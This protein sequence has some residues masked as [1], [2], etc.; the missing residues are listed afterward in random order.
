MSEGAS[1]SPRAARSSQKAAAGS[2]P[3]K[4]AIDAAERAFSEAW[5]RALTAFSPYTRL[6]PP[7]LCRT[8]SDEK[9]EGLEQSFAM[10]RMRDERI[11]IGLS[12]IAALSLEP[13]A[14][15]ILAHE[16]GHYVHAPG[17]LRDHVRLHDR[18]RRTLPKNLAPHAGMVSNLYTDLLLNDR[19]ER[20]GLAD[21]AAVYVALRSEA[22]S[23]LWTFYMRTYERLWLLRP[24]TL[25]PEPSETIESDAELAA[26]LVRHFR[27]DW[28]SGAPSFALL[29]APYL[30]SLPTERPGLPGWLD[31][32]ATSLGEQVPDGLV[33]DDFD[34]DQVQHPAVDARLSDSGASDDPDDD[35]EGDAAADAGDR[36]G[37]GEGSTVARDRGARGRALRGDGR[38]DERR[39]VRGPQQWIEL[40]RAAGVQ[41]EPSQLLARYYRELAQP[42]V[43]PFPAIRAERAGDPLPEGLDPWEP[44]SPL[45]AIDWLES[46]LRSPLVVPG[47]TTV[48]RS[49]GTTEGGEPERIAPDL[50]VG[51]DCSGS[52]GNP[53][54]QLAHPIVAAVVLVLSALRAGARA[55]ACLSGEWHGQGSF[56]DT[57]GFVRD[58][59]A[60]LGV[61]TSY[62]GTGASFGLPRLA[63]TFGPGF[64]SRRPV[65]VVVVSD[66]DFF[67]EVDGTKNGWAIL[68]SA[69]ARAG[70]GATAVL[71]LHAHAAYDSWLASMR[72]AGV[73]PHIVSSEEELVA[74]ARAF[75]RRTYRPSP[76]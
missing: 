30:E 75:A 74:F 9:R 42:H 68:K 64:R 46:L 59:R 53:A 66:S 73:E 67:A 3:T 50:Y 35:C 70:G 52:M 76:R 17:T 12:Q 27:D 18:I 63:T 10:I 41:I 37:V 38:P 54:H 19:L 61:L 11:V 60:L 47:V 48:E 23:E 45:E 1:A 29:V 58:E 4:S 7:I 6:A 22:T 40:L 57:G 49:F 5:P 72:E 8:K 13:H 55:M 16:V 32:A 2:R 33:D 25:G 36:D 20:G 62:L 28:L 21:I 31:T 34:P 56:V 15:A 71:R 65:H 44:G 14:H 24:R 69:V 51:I 39:V 26:R 43:I